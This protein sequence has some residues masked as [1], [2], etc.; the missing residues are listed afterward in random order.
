MIYLFF[1]PSDCFTKSFINNFATMF[2]EKL[3]SHENMKKMKSYQVENIIYLDLQN[4]VLYLAKSDKNE[5]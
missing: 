4:H 2:L 3:F 5:I 1:L